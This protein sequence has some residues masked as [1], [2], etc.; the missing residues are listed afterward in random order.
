MP[1]CRLLLACETYQFW[2]F[3]TPFFDRVRIP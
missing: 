2:F 1:D 3:S